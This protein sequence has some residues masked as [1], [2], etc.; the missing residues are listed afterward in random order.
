MLQVKETEEMGQWHAEC[1]PGLDPAP[2]EKQQQWEGAL[3]T[4]IGENS[5]V[6]GFYIS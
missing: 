6:C 3:G 1:R 4:Q 2:G 5:R